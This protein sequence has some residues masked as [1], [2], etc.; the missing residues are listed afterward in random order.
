MAGEA[1]TNQQ[2]QYDSRLLE[3]ER[4]VAIV[5]IPS[6]FPSD[7]ESAKGAGV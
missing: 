4:D 5:Y 6:L 7:G 3:R 1:M 2:S